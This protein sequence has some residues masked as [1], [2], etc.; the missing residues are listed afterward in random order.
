MSTEQYDLFEALPYIRPE[1]RLVD[2]NLRMKS[3]MKA[4]EDRLEKMELSL[5]KQRKAL[6][7]RHGAL[8]K[9]YME[10]LQQHEYIV[11]A[12]CKSEK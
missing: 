1:I 7:A 12:L 11:S 4:L 10:L 3:K 2:D 6:F 8:A 9:M 5:D